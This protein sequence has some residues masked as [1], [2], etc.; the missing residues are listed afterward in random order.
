MPR[1]TLAL[2]LALLPCIAA[3]GTIEFTEDLRIDTT[4]TD[5]EFGRVYSVAVAPNG[6]LYVIDT[7]FGRVHV[8]GPDGDYRRSW[9]RTGEGP[10]DLP[11]RM[12][13]VTAD[14]QGNLLVAGPRSS[15]ARLD[16]FGDLVE[17]IP[18]TQV[19]TPHS[20]FVLAN[21]TLGLT[22]TYVNFEPGH[23]GPPVLIHLF[24]RSGEELASF[25]GS[26]WWKDD[27]DPGWASA[28]FASTAA[29]G[30][31]GQTIV[32]VQ[33]NPFE[34]RRYQP[35]GTLLGRTSEGLDQ[36]VPEPRLPEVS[37]D[38]RRFT[39]PGGNA[40]SVTVTAD[41]HI[42]VNASRIVPEDNDPAN[43]EQEG[44]RP[45]WE[46]RMAVYDMDLE[47]LAVHGPDGTPYVVGAASGNRI[48]AL[49][50]NDEDIQILV[51]YRY[52]LAD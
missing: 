38:S 32:F 21:G 3:A 31:E 22:W 35:D 11:Q 8:F 24:D 47:L 9:G 52:T 34:L 39:S 28:L 44:F 16:P 15:I 17:S 7:G 27:Y 46:R 14:A 23:T 49:D 36:F 30:P 43:W 6:T 26:S 42:F 20:L 41:G 13:Q 37:G 29:A 5:A 48:W 10:G 19:P 45:R 18:L 4:G 50:S 33:S 25:A 51:R 1:F 40:G 12:I 2:A